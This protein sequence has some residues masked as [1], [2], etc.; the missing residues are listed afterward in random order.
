MTLVMLEPADLGLESSTLPLSHCAPY[1]SVVVVV[2][3]VSLF[4]LL[5]LRVGG[6]SWFLI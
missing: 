4:V 2:V 5:L 1:N 3:V 6:L